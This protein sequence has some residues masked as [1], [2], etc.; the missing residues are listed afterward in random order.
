MPTARTVSN[1]AASWPGRS[2]QAAIQF[3]DSLMSPIRSTGAAARFVIA[4]PTAMRP[5]A[6]ASIAAIGVRSP[7]AIASPA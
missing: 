6:A 7:I 4:S 2:P 1:S 3:A 5:D